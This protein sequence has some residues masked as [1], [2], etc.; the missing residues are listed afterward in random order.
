M[1]SGFF[2]SNILGYDDY[3][4]P[5]YD[6]AEEASFFAAFFADFIGN[7][8]YPNPSTGL[9]VLANGGLELKVQKGSCFINGYRGVVEEGG[10]TITLDAANT[11]YNRIDRIVARLDIEERQITLDVLKG[12][13]GSNPVAVELTRNSNIYE[14]GLADIVVNKKAS[15]ITQSDIT[16]TR[17]NS[18]LCGVVCGVIEQIDTTTLFNQY[19]SWFNEMKQESSENYQKWF[20]GFTLP[21]EQEF[22]DW[23]DGVKNQLSED[24]AGNLQNQINDL[25]QSVTA[26]SDALKEV[27]LSAQNKY[28]PV[29]STYF[30]LV[31]SRNPNIILGFGEWQRIEGRFLLGA[32]DKYEAGTEGGEESHKLTVE[33]LASHSHSCTTVKYETNGS[34]IAGSGSSKYDFTKASST[35]SK[36]GNKAHNNMPP[37]RAGY[38][39]ERIA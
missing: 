27:E 7:G 14:L 23:F 28:Y 17:L 21:S 2:N 18:S 39:W 4:N 13:A 9:Q 35:G 5:I 15:V 38:L 6:R 22:N 32:S 25:V 33:E 34:S 24:A 1:R 8:V 12:T 29:G 20:D 30:N 19:V 11:S 31:D 3:G 37:Y 16:D 26:L 36:G 10:E